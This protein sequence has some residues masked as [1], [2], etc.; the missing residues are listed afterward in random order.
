MILSVCVIGLS[1]AGQKFIDEFKSRNYYKQS[2]EDRVAARIHCIHV[3]SLLGAQSGGYYHEKPD[4]TVGKIVSYKDGEEETSRR[5]PLGS[6]LEF[7]IETDGHRTI[8]EFIE[9]DPEGYLEAIR[10]QFKEGGYDLHITSESLLPYQN[11]FESLAAE[12]GAKVFF[13]TGA[14]AVEKVLSYLDT[15]FE[16]EAALQGEPCGLDMDGVDWS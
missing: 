6:D 3:A 10:S 1:G 2:D 16:K 4:E 12:V 13:Y 9:Q 15:K 11:E 8:V 5:I 7:L 14:S